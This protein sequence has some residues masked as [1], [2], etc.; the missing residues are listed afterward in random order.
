MEKIRDNLA[1]TLDLAQYQPLYNT[2]KS[3]LADLHLNQASVLDQLS[4]EAQEEVLV[5]INLARNWQIKLLERIHSLSVN[6]ATA[7]V[8]NKTQHAKLPEIKLSTFSGNFDE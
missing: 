6:Q 4:Q 1:D 2:L 3:K 7:A 8:T 5:N